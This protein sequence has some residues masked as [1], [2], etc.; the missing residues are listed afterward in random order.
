MSLPDVAGSPDSP[1][2][3]A[4]S[5][6]GA[7]LISLSRQLAAAECRWLALL[8]EFDRREGWRLDG[9]L[10]GVNQN[11][12]RNSTVQPDEATFSVSVN[13]ASGTTLETLP[14][15]TCRY[16]CGD[17]SQTAFDDTIVTTLRWGKNTLRISFF[18]LGVGRLRAVRR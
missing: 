4:T 11:V 8:A 5:E 16:G 17:F 3:W 10:S 6:L 2:A 7:A 18:E 13:T 12:S 14:G 15:V 9:Q 1:E